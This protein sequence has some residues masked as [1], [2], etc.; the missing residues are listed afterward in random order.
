MLVVPARAGEFVEWGSTG[1]S[2][3][4][5]RLRDSPVHEEHFAEG[6]HH[7]VGRLD[8]AVNEAPLVREGERV[9]ELPEDV[10]APLERP[11]SVR[12]R[13]A[14]LQALEDRLEGLA[15]HAGHDEVERAVVVLADVVDGHDVRVLER[16]DRPDL[17]DE[18]GDRLG[19]LDLAAELLDGDLAP[20]V[21]IVG[22]VDLS[23]P[24]FP[25]APS[26]LEARSRSLDDVR[27]V[28][29]GLDAREHGRATRAPEGAGGR[30]RARHRPE[31]G[32]VERADGTDGIEKRGVP[33]GGQVLRLHAGAVSPG[34]GTLHPEARRWRE[35][36]RAVRAGTCGKRGSA[37]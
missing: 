11:V 20:D 7:D 8:V 2:G 23:E 13:V 15:P 30:L 28:G 6:A 14:R 3:G 31:R 32:D 18:A 26:G 25:E 27:G 12:R 9:E 17:V 5:D 22:R 29:R 35:A 21:V 16:P 37:G 10:Q 33:G 36:A 4:A 24:P 19:A 34:D 1:R